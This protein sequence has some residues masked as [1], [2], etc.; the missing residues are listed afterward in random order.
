MHKDISTRFYTRFAVCLSQ[1]NKKKKHGK[2]IY[3]MMIKKRT[4]PVRGCMTDSLIQ[5]HRSRPS[6][7]I[8]HACRQKIPAFPATLSKIKKVAQ[9]LRCEMKMIM[10]YVGKK[11]IIINDKVKQ[12]GISVQNLMP[13]H[14][15]PWRLLV[16]W[17]GRNAVRRGSARHTNG[18]DR[19]LHRAIYHGTSVRRRFLICYNLIIFRRVRLNIEEQGRWEMVVAAAAA[20]RGGSGGHGSRTFVRGVCAHE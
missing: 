6:T 8:H 11:I 15:P 20:M 10:F 3:K 13:Q 9:L 4:L 5:R 7:Y 1:K 2:N 14:S 19:T 12:R 18:R 16:N 17:R